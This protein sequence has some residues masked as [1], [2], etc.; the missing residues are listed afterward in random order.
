[1]QTISSAAKPIQFS[2]YLLKN[3]YLLI[4]EIY[5]FIDLRVPA[6]ELSADYE[7]QNTYQDYHQEGKEI[8]HKEPPSCGLYDIVCGYAFLSHPALLHDMKQRPK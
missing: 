8:I 7:S 4:H 3:P 2:R 5:T 1:M 6:E